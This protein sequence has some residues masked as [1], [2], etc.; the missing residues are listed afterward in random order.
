M[1]TWTVS[2]AGENEA[3]CHAAVTGHQNTAHGT[4]DWN[5]T[6]TV[7]TCLNDAVGH[8]LLIAAADS[9]LTRAALVTAV[10]SRTAS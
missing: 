3:G 5:A 2:I 4:V 8:P 6:G 10:A 1:L 9:S 7:W